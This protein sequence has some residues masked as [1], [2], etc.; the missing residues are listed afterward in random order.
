MA[1]KLQMAQ[2]I[3]SI[4]ARDK[5]VIEHQ[6]KDNGNVLFVW[7]DTEIKERFITVE[8]ANDGKLMRLEKENVISENRSLSEVYLKEKVLQF[9]GDHYPNAAEKFVSL[10]KKVTDHTIQYTYSQTVLGLPLPQTGFLVTIMRS[11]VIKYFRYYGMTDSYSIPKQIAD[12]QQM[13]SDYLQEVKFKLCIA[14]CNDLLH[15]AYEPL[16]PFLCYQPAD[17]SKKKETIDMKEDDGDTEITKLPL[18]VDHENVV[19]INDMIGFDHASF[20]KIRESDLGTMI[21]TVW[22]KGN[23]P[24]SIERSLDGY[25]KNRNQNTLKIMTDKKTGKLRGVM[26]L[27]ECDGPSVWT[28]EACR[29]RALQFLYQLY[30][31]AEQFFHIHPSDNQ[32]AEKKTFFQFDTM[33][34]GVPVRSGV[35]NIGIS[36]VTGHVVVFQC[37][38][39]DL[40]ILECLN[41]SPSISIEEAKAIFNAAF[42]VKLEWLKDEGEKYKLVYRLV[43]PDLIDAHSGQLCHVVF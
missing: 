35:V 27:I 29:K 10:E 28:I 26:S 1:N 39:T 5:L 33:Y 34:K 38:E 42:D 32:E 23:E 12:K 25:F 14:E 37:P 13:I 17:L 19:N 3:G 11:G 24:Q 6:G 9:V 15:L 20:R 21:G 7:E 16:S 31:F 2:Q 22:R 41:L 4:S 8:I 18:L 36:R 43:F 40:D 30:P